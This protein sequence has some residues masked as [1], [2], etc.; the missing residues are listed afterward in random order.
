MEQAISLR[1]TGV[2]E[3]MAPSTGTPFRFTIDL[4]QLMRIS[5]DAVFVLTVDLK[6]SWSNIRLSELSG[7]TAEELTGLSLSKLVRKEVA[8]GTETIHLDP[9]GIPDSFEGV[10]SCKDGA[11]RYVIVHITRIHES[12]QLVGAVGF[13]YD[14]TDVRIAAEKAAQADKL[15]ALGQLA[16]GVAHN[17]NN[18]LAAMLGHIQLLKRDLGNS[19]LTERVEII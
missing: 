2:E 6:L 16:G 5:R 3:T 7:F 9:G 4:S 12:G 13:L 1:Q 14:I 8:G 10:L 17:F 19:P 15:R 11:R 18:I